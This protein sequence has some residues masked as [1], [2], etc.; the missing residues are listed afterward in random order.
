MSDVIS[1]ALFFIA[2]PRLCISMWKN[3][4]LRRRCVI[5]AAS[6]NSNTMRKWV[7]WYSKLDEQTMMS[8]KY[9]RENCCLIVIRIE[10]T[11]S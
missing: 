9:T 7:L 11:A 5:P 2:Y 1:N 3:L 10:S 4:D 6:I 8:C